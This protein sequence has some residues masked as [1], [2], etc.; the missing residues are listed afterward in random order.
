MKCSISYSRKVQT[1]PYE[2]V[3]LGYTR[4]FESTVSSPEEVLRECIGFVEEHL[5]KQKGWITQ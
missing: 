3:S 5:Q 4:E 2:N 1:Q